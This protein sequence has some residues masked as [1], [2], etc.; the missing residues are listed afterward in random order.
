MALFK[1]TL[2]D[3]IIESSRYMCRSLM[4]VA[5]VPKKSVKKPF[6]K[7]EKLTALSR[8]LLAETGQFSGKSIASELL[9]S[10]R[11]SNP[12][13][14]IAFLAVLASDFGP[15]TEKLESAWNVYRSSKNA[16]KHHSLSI[17]IEA[18]RQELFR[19]L[20]QGHQATATLVAMRAE[21]M[22]AMRVRP[23][24]K[25]VEDDLSHIFRSWFNQGFLKMR[26]IDWSSPADILERV[27]RY[28]AVHSISTWEELKSRLLPDDRRCYAF[29]HPSMGDEPL[30]FVE[31]ALT[32]Y[33]P[34]SIQNLL[35]EDRSIISADEA[36]VATF[37]SINNCQ[38]GLTGISF[39]NALIK[40][41]V[42]DISI[43]FPGL[44][45][46]VTLSPVPGFAEW[47]RSIAIQGNPEAALALT[48]IDQP[49]LHE[50]THEAQALLRLS[51]AYFL[52]EKDR[53]G[54][55]R[56]PVERFHLWNGAKLDRLCFMGDK[57][58]TGLE[59]SVGL[60]VNYS[61]DLA[62]LEFNH[63]QHVHDGTIAASKQVRSYLQKHQKRVDRHA[64]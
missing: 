28:E 51:A 20:N 24:L 39:G 11:D 53:H 55:P 50:N 23:E 42:E 49:E 40:Q 29:F 2:V 38:A 63:E 7:V 9:A 60:M 21:L 15:D 59:R 12:T 1:L 37:Y 27:I 48:L 61:Y 57:S 62:E 36:S 31:V 44:K 4:Q 8:K 35:A 25:V 10:Y 6:A 16:S 47:L 22:V 17:A 41:V 26:R 64:E 14:R 3:S 34:N 18:P 33:I 43:S 58:K 54:R 13:E 46:F 56:D 19:R 32:T 30:I 52:L 45:N 5:V